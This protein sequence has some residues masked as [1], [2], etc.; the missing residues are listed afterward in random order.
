MGSKKSKKKTSKA[1]APGSEN[2]APSLEV[3]DEGHKV[4]ASANGDLSKSEEIDN[5]ASSI[6]DEKSVPGKDLSSDSKS[7]TNGSAEANLDEPDATDS[8]PN[9]GNESTTESPTVN[10]D[11]PD[12]DTTNQQKTAGPGQTLSPEKVEKPSEEL[13]SLR[14]KLAEAES[15]RDEAQDAYDNLVEKLTH[16]KSNLSDRLK[17]D[18]EAVAKLTDQNTL[19]QKELEL[20]RSDRQETLDALD[21]HHQQQLAE[22][23]SLREATEVELA[24]AQ[25]DLASEITESTRYKDL[26]ELLERR[27]AQTTNQ[28]ATAVAEL[29]QELGTQHRLLKDIQSQLHGSQQRAEQAEAE[30]GKSAHFQARIVELESSVKEKNLLIGKLRHEAVILNDHLTNALRL[31]KKDAEGQTVDKELISNLFIQYATVPRQDTKKFEILQLIA[32]FL[33]WDEERRAQVGLARL[34]RAAGSY[35]SGIGGVFG[36]FAEFLER[37]S[38]KS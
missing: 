36:K 18:A 31:V 14:Q 1:S 32:N 27:L 29:E 11:K 28:K 21:V 19:L 26:C 9:T 15:E 35:E 37:E 16:V 12:S 4:E 25:S 38:K 8:V 17:K 13:E 34:G 7:Q 22:Q 3:E 24:K 23:R 2:Q 33:G 20:A 6:Q 5:P 30:A 10:S